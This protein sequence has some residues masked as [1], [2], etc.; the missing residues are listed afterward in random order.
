MNTSRFHQSASYTALF[1]AA[2]LPTLTACEDDES[3]PS[4][5]VGVAQTYKGVTRKYYIAA[6][7]VEWD[8]APFGMDMMEGRPFTPEQEVFVKGDGATLI[9]SKYK[10]ALYR[11][12]TD[13]TFTKL[14]GE[15]P[16]NGI[17]GPIIHAAVGDKIEVVFKNNAEALSY[18]VHPHGVFYG[19]DG[20]GA[21]SDDGT[22]G[23]DVLDDAVPPGETFT[24]KWKVPERSGPGPADGS[25]VVWLYH[26]HV[27]A[28]ADE[29]SGLI[30][31]IVVTDPRFADE[32]GKPKDVDQ[33]VFDLFMVEDENQSNYLL[34]NVAKYAP[35][36]LPDEDDL[37]P[38]PAPLADAGALDAGAPPR[39]GGPGVM[40]VA[41]EEFEE[42]NLMHAI[43]GYV[44]ANGP[45]PEL[46]VGS[47][48]RWYLMTLGTEVD[49]HTPHWHGNT[50][51]SLGH[52]TDV[53]ELL[54]A[55][56][57]VADMVPDDP[58]M[59]MFHCHVNDH[60][61]AGMVGMY[62]VTR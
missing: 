3:S 18:S 61:S 1:L 17:L 54:P 33:E 28:V 59:W 7:E 47:R 58:G 15:W 27:Q 26:S 8:Y 32:Q 52:R 42:S 40:P 24:Y 16:K 49:L 35:Y 19:K 55:T 39:D 5:E 45:M 9:G 34:D 41:P 23:K 6:D 25:S 37:A 38:V 11:E 53:V 20:E 21:G 12:Y 48:V 29:Y 2:L 57:V 56:M 62:S 13:A 14:K 10:K 4:A 30:G 22:S 51:L 43:N 31:A 36:A 50:V 44:Y 46:K 60:I